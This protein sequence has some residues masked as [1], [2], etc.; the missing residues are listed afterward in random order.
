MNSEASLIPDII[1][2]E[3]LKLSI[4]ASPE[5]VLVLDQQK[6]VLYYNNN[7][8]AMWGIARME[9]DSHDDALLSK[10]LS[11][12][13][14]PVEYA[15]RVNEIYAQPD[16]TS[17][18]Q[19]AL[20]DGRILER[21]GK[22]IRGE[23]GKYYAWAWFF[24]DITQ[25]KQQ[26]QRH[27]QILNSLPQL[28]WTS[29]AFGVPDYYNKSWC[30]YTG[31]SVEE[32][33][34]N[35]WQSIVHP[36]DLAEGLKHR[37]ATLKTRETFKWEARYRRW[38]GMYRWHIMH[39]EPVKEGD[40][41]LYWV[42]TCTDVDDLKRANEQLEASKEELNSLANAMP[43]L[44]WIADNNGVVDFY[45]NR[46]EEFSGATRLEDGR[47][48]WA[49][50]IHPEDEQLTVDAWN[51]AIKEGVTYAV[52]HRVKM[53]NGSYKWH[54]SRSFPQRNHEG[55]IIKWY[56][57][58]TD[59]HELKQLER[60]LEQRVKE[61]SKEL[62]QQKNLL[63]SILKHS[64]AGI[65]VYTAIRNAEGVVV[66]FQCILANDAAQTYT[67]LSNEERYSKTV[68]EITPSLEG[69]PL[70]NM[71]ITAV[72]EG[73]SFRTEFYNE[74]LQKW[75]ELVVVKMYENHLI[76]V[77]RDIT[78]IKETQ[79]QLEKHID[80]LKRTNSNL[81]EF[82]YAASHDLQEPVRKMKIFTDRLKKSLEDQ[83]DAEQEKY[84]ER[85]EFAVSRMGSLIDDLLLFSFVTK[86]ATFEDEVDLNRKVDLV[87]QDLE[88]EVEETGAKITIDNLPTISAHKRQLQQ[89]FQ[90]LLTNALKYRKP[91]VPPEISISCSRLKGSETPVL[92]PAEHASKEFYKLQIKDNGIG[93][94]EQYATEI[95][96]LFSRLHGNNYTGTGIGLS[97]VQK[98]VENH[99]GYI[100]AESKV[101]E[102][103]T[104]NILF[105]VEH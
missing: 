50:L 31:K 63:D 80:D 39:A 28:V 38:D 6:Q 62:I 73:K 41:V 53:K 66:D 51:H 76:N 42:G 43:Q 17:H 55:E 45:N 7:Y 37:Q 105:P 14:D 58:A 25:I 100:W 35:G 22:P 20:K 32:L 21:Y 67:G 87:L 15:R 84:F 5:A 16:V 10:A 79:L 68:L 77:F 86:G 75:L 69:S 104:F 46:I 27:Q 93:F 8:A 54:L 94:E 18:D 89:L 61:R 65:S 23:D 92:M 3:V 103:A 47:W 83:L 81:E 26:E 57:T 1:N 59:I 19:V 90:N 88:L 52:E 98:I 33:M 48:K 24:R 13:K 97:I 9:H 4:E 64:P 72:E 40:E 36:A 91:G 44:V 2:K 11:K 71:A 60:E 99:G 102:G 101:G 85:V 29:S 74:N 96:K 56:G 82:A 12:V 95:F 78:P 30:N 49:G 70:H 34:G